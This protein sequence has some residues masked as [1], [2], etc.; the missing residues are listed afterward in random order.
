M[1]RQKIRLSAAEMNTDI[2]NDELTDMERIV[3]HVSSN[4]NIVPIVADE[5]SNQIF[6]PEPGTGSTHLRQS[7]KEN[8]AIYN[9]TSGIARSMS[10]I[11][12]RQSFAGGSD[13]GGV[14]VSES[15]DG[16]TRLGPSK[17]KIKHNQG[18]GNSHSGSPNRKVSKSLDR[19]LSGQSK[20]LDRGFSGLSQTVDWQVS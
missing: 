6:R 3:R 14:T 5:S 12:K 18:L 1:D 17:Q 15:G 16:S 20:S 19:G 13:S 7:P 4:I 11:S 9:Q 8:L 10:K 2:D